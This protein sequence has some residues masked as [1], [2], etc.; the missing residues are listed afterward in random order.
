LKLISFSVFP[1]Q[2]EWIFAGDHPA[3]F[4]NLSFC[5]LHGLEYR[6]ALHAALPCEMIW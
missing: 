2:F 5:E 4:R 1:S 6:N 3:L